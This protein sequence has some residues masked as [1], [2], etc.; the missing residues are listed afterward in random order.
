MDWRLEHK[1]ETIK[2]LDESI[3]GKFLGVGFGDNL[4]G[5]MLKAKATSKNRQVEPY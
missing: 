1:T 3:G 5:L 2:L 4:G